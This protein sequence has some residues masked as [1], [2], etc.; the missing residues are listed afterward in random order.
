MATRR[1]GQ[2]ELVYVEQ[3]SVRAIQDMAREFKKRGNGKALQKR[4]NTQIKAA[5]K[6]L[7]AD[8][9]A[10]AR[11]MQFRGTSAGQRARRTEGV[12]KT[13]RKRKGM[14][15]RDAL[16]KGI[17]TEI[18][19]RQSAGAGVRIRLKSSDTEINQLGRTL[20]RR[21]FIRHPTRT[22]YRFS[23]QG[24]KWANTAATNARDWFWSPVPKH[25]A[26]VTNGVKDAV[27]DM[28]DELARDIG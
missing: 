18:S 15:L 3:S 12:T 9:K 25:R 28:L 10:N 4:L 22:G 5:T 19:Y 8:I 6:P 21:G 17:K 1:T 20:N 26:K 27:D 16:V 13:G 24:E 2:S 23:K 11:G 7:E 14:G